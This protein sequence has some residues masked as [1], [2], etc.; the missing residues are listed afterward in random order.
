M[1]NLSSEVAEGTAHLLLGR[2]TA[3]VVGM[4]G[5]FIIVNLLGPVDY[6]L[7]NIAVILPNL[8]GLFSDLGITNA[9]TKDLSKYLSKGHYSEMRRTAYTGLLTSSVIAIILSVIV[10]LTAEIFTTQVIGK[11]EA[12]FLTR[13]AALLIIS[14]TLEKYSSQ[15]LLGL[16]RTKTYAQLIVLNEAI[17]APLPIIL[18]FLGM[19]VTGVLIGMITPLLIVGVIGS[20]ATIRRV[21]T[22]GQKQVPSNGYRTTFIQMVSFSLP[23]WMGTI[24]ITGLERYNDFLKATYIS[25]AEIGNFALAMMM[26]F[27]TGKIA[28][29]PWGRVF[30]YTRSRSWRTYH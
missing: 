15:A 24:F 13:I 28:F 11:P 22:L 16:G 5:G 1:K 10:F 19:G 17:G 7:I 30:P 2:I 26:F 14:M 3:K 18:F 20:F 25:I 27:K 9:V 4:L 23:L 29:T 21:N 6:G 8:L 12:A